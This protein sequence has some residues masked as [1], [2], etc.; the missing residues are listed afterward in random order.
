MGSPVLAMNNERILPWQMCLHSRCRGINPRCWGSVSAQAGRACF[1][2]TQ[3][4]HAGDPPTA[5]GTAT[6]ADR[7][8]RIGR[9]AFVLHPAHVRDAAR[10]TGI[11]RGISRW[12]RHWLRRR[13]QP[14]LQAGP[15][16]G[17]A[18]RGPDLR[19]WLEGGP[20][21]LRNQLRANSENHQSDPIARMNA[22]EAAVR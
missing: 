19:Q 6:E 14:L 4:D 16:S 1:D 9:A 10:A 20:L 2:V 11:P 12:V 7:L 13:G 17:H 5:P 15:G 22:Q 21:R 8:G 18:A 3:V